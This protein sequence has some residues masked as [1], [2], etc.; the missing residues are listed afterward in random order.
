MGGLFKT[1][2][3]I[4]AGIIG[5]L[6][7]LPVASLPFSATVRI[8]ILCLTALPLVLLALIG[9]A[10]GSLSSFILLFFSFLRNR[11]VLSQE[12]HQEKRKN[13]L[14]P[15]WAV[16]QPEK[17]DEGEN[18]PKSR[19]R[20]SINLKEHKVT[21]FKTFL[22]SEDALPPLNPL[23]GYIPIEKI[24]NGVI[25]TSTAVDTE[26]FADLDGAGERNGD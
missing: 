4:E 5:F 18:T 26:S 16:R 3:V 20:I 9:V 15:S 8:V 6:V 23:A 1:R 7:G 17:Q 13:T 22:P 24:E 14:L 25:Y 11:R 10:G 21:Q 12:T 2:N 19:S